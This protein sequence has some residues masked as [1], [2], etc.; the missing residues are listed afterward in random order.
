M[1]IYAETTQ[2]ILKHLSEGVIPWRRTWT[3]GLPCSLRTGREYRG[4]NILSL[5]A[6][7]YGS[8]DWVT[9]RHALR[10]GGHVRKGEKA[11]PVAYWH[12]RTP[13]D[14]ARLKSKTGKS[15]FAPCVPFISDVF[16]LDQVEGVPR[17]EE[18]GTRNR[19]RRLELADNLFDMM[20]DKPEIVHSRLNHSGYSYREDR[21]SLPHLSQF[22]SADEYYATLFREL[23]HASGA[24]HRL[25]R[26]AEPEGDRIAQN[27]FEELVA[28]FGASFLCA[29]AGIDNASIQALA[30]SDIRG[31]AEAFRH[32]ERLLLRAASAAQKA[33]DYVRGKLVPDAGAEPPVEPQP[34]PDVAT[35]FAA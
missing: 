31:W 5:I 34:D 11:T 30:P 12:W 17:P 26:F 2:R 9:Y 29:F 7:G 18:A 23:V 1:N 15:D 4:V 10:L 16:N 24:E 19:D 33:A 6:A 28:E 25:N 27:L 13:E 35:S 32:D 20:P 14:F 21:I 3:T 8:R 22:V